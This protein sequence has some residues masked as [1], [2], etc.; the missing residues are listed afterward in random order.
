M[1]YAMAIFFKENLRYS[2]FFMF[3]NCFDLCEAKIC[4]FL[5]NCVIFSILSPPYLLEIKIMV[6]EKNLKKNKDIHNASSTCI[7]ESVPKNLILFCEIWVLTSSFF[8]TS[9]RSHYPI[10]SPQI[11]Q[12]NWLTYCSMKIQNY[13]CDKLGFLFLDFFMSQYPLLFVDSIYASNLVPISQVACTGIS[14]YSSI[15][16][17]Y[18]HDTCTWSR[19]FPVLYL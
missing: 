13:L 2:I 11:K 17:T 6:R 5:V 7:I 8:G 15:T 1:D 4:H 18:T 10:F 19:S 16:V 12:E 3:R 14:G 9:L